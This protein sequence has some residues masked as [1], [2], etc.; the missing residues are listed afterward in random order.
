MLLAVSTLSTSH[1]FIA[2]LFLSL[3]FSSHFASFM[4]SQ[5]TRFS[6]SRLFSTLFTVFVC[7]IVISQQIVGLLRDICTYT[8][9][10]G[11][12]M[13]NWSLIQN[14]ILC[15]VLGLATYMAT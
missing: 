4:C 9:C 11:T 14:K 7:A 15:F 13:V 8:V 3:N 10:K 1:P 12:G 6:I 2:P 5:P